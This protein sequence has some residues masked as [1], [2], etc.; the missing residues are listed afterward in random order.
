MID[1]P[2]RDETSDPTLPNPAKLVTRDP[3]PSQ[4]LGLCTMLFENL[5]VDRI[6]LK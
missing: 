5:C 1:L 3:F 6:R 4:A 2:T